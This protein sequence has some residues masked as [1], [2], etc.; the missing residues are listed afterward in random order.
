MPSLEKILELLRSPEESERRHGI[1]D[2]VRSGLPT[3][4]NILSDLAHKDSSLEIRYY[5]RRAL[6]SLKKKAL[7]EAAE[8]LIKPSMQNRGKSLSELLGSLDPNIRLEGLKMAFE[9][10]DI[11]TLRFIRIGLQRESLP[12]LR[13]AFITVL[14]RFGQKADVPQIC[15]YLRDIDPRVRAT[16]VEALSSLGT[17]PAFFHLVPML[18]DVDDRV[19]MN[20]IKALEKYGGSS[21][22]SLLQQMALEG[23]I[24]M[25]DSALFG[26]NYFK[27]PYSMRVLGEIAETDPEEKLR[28]KAID[29]LRTNARKGSTE[30]R[31]ILAGLGESIDGTDDESPVP[32]GFENNDDKRGRRRK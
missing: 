26:L 30:A 31:E 29:Y 2:L 15:D 25:R 18:E 9:D 3:A 16:A 8:N 22:F 7:I 14:G 28:D 11:A 6:D 1:L 23:E 20:T 19:K 32:P 12:E 24:W 10:A 17:Q 21:L 13:A 5:A 27:I 4:V